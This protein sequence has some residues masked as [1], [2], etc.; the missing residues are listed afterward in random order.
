MPDPQTPN[1]IHASFL[2]TLRRCRPSK[3]SIRRSADSA[4]AQSSGEEALDGLFGAGGQKQQV[5]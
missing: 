3:G 5:A 1:D 2:T 4:K